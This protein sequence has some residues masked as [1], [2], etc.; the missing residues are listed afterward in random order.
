MEHDHPRSAHGRFLGIL[1][2]KRHILFVAFVVM[3]IALVILHVV[4]ASSIYKAGGFSLK[5]P[6]SYWMIGGFLV[7]A[8]FKL[9]YLWRFKSII[10]KH[11]QK[12]FIGRHLFL[13]RPY[14]FLA[15]SQRKASSLALP[16]Q[17][18]RLIRPLLLSMV[19][20]SLR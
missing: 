20:A 3:I 11:L 9:L 2:G 4:L 18:L 6:Y 12:C 5:S 7:V 17:T 19:F 8:T 15:A 13:S 16:G 14:T 10:R 1:K